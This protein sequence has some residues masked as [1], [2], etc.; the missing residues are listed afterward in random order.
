MGVPPMLSPLFCFWNAET[1][2]H[3]SSPRTVSWAL[4]LQNSGPPALQNVAPLLQ[5]GAPLTH[6]G[7]S[8]IQNVA[9][10]SNRNPKTVFV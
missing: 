4:I 2:R 1:L 3:Y 7:A 9:V 5:T 10:E 6:F 8:M